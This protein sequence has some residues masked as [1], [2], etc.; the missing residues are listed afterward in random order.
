MWPTL[1][2]KSNVDIL[3]LFA[4]SFYSLYFAHFYAIHSVALQY[5][6]IRILLKPVINGTKSS[7]ILGQSLK[8]FKTLLFQLPG[9][10]IIVKIKF[11]TYSPSLVSNKDSKDSYYTLKSKTSKYI[12][13]FHLL[14]WFNVSDKIWV[15]I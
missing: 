9:F 1:I 6:L 13:L 10:E 12:P 4:S 5:T 8:I 11:V 3:S 14:Y 7:M 2:P 15:L